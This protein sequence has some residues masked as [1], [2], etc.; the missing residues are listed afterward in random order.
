MN[1]TP[2]RWREFLDLVEDTRQ[3]QRIFRRTQDPMIRREVMQLEAFLDA[4]AAGIAIDL[5]PAEQPAEP[6]IVGE[7]S[8]AA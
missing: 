8:A 4:T 5:E 3:L 2:E 1:I 6:A 7:G